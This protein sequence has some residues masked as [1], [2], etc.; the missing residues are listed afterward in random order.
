MK[1]TGECKM[2]G[3]NAV[4]LYD[5]GSELQN[6]FGRSLDESMGLL[7][8][9][10]RASF[11]MILPSVTPP[12]VGGLVDFASLC[13]FSCVFLLLTIPGARRVRPYFGIIGSRENENRW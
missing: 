13:G 12:M 4:G 7:K 6:V 10:R 2:R 5:K 11:K 3:T 1:W 8:R 9:G